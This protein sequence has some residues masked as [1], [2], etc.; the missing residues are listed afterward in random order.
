MLR[1]FFRARQAMKFQDQEEKFT[2]AI[3]GVLFVIVVWRIFLA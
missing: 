1:L 3:L 2:L